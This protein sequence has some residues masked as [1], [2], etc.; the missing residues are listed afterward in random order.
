MPGFIG[1]LRRASRASRRER[2][3]SLL[4]EALSALPSAPSVAECIERYG[5]EYRVEH[6]TF[7]EP[8]LDDDGRCEI[9]FTYHLR[10]ATSA[11]DV[12]EE[13]RGSGLAW[14]D[15]DGR[16]RLGEVD[17]EFFRFHD[18]VGPS[19]DDGG[20]APTRVPLD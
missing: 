5:G 14:I 18:D 4:R 6:Y 8:L 11:R 2:I 13:I 1:S 7:D 3:E 12:S 10:E 15:D 19:G 9:Q 17:A 20:A 16:I